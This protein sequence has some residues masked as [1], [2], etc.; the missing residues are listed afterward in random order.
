MKSLFLYLMVALYIGSGINHFLNAP[1]YMKIMPSW[2]PFHSGLV[3]I[4]GICEVLF[5]ILL[6]PP[7]TRHISA[8]LLILLLIAVFPANIQM[9]INYWRSSNPGLW[10]TILRLPMQIVLILWAWFYTKE[11]RFT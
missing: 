2:L 5:A 1:M 7:A 8:W 10:M 4:S 9:A 3:Y 6:L 11:S